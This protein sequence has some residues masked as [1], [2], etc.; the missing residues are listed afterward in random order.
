M[1]IAT[2]NRSD[3]LA[4]AIESVL[5]QS[6]RDWEMWVIGDACTDDTEDVVKSFDDPRM[7]FENLPVN[8]GE[9]SGPN[10][11]GAQRARGRYVA[12]LNHDDLW[13]P[14]HLEAAAGELDVSGADLVFSLID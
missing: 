10:N 6:L 14:D 12:Y 9:Q 1:I 8:V 2:Y 4:L 3:V 13:T 7:S 11:A 5:Q